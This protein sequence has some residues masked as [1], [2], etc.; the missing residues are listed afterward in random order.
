MPAG[1]APPGSSRPNKAPC[2]CESGTVPLGRKGRVAFF[3]LVGYRTHGIGSRKTRARKNRVSLLV[4]VYCT[5]ASRIKAPPLQPDN[6][7]IIRTVEHWGSRARIASARFPAFSSNGRLEWT[8]TPDKAPPSGDPDLLSSVGDDSA[9]QEGM[10]HVP[11]RKKRVCRFPDSPA[12]GCPRRA[13][14]PRLNRPKG[15]SRRAKGHPFA[16]TDYS[17]KKVFLVSAEGKVDLGIC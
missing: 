15:R 6:M 4:A 5:M 3:G 14:P 10:H 17:Q 9:A 16:C 7:Q 8:G 12:A 13:A 1:T 2:R 11:R